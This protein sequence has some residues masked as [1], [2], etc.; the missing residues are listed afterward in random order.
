MMFFASIAALAALGAVAR[1][2]KQRR[3]PD[4]GV[5]HY[6]DGSPRSLGQG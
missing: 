4:E 1:M 5:T 2:V 3:A 6:G